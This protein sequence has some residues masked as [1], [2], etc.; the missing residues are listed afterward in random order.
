MIIALVRHAQFHQPDDVPSALLPYG[1]TNTGVLQAEQAGFK[2][3][4]FTEERHL[5]C[6]PHIDCSLMLR[7]WQTAKVIAQTLETQHSVEFEIE[8]H[9]QLAERSLGAVAN[10]TVPEIELAIFGDPRYSTP[11]EGWKTDSD[12]CLP[13]QGAE[14]LTE[15]GLRVAQYL[16]ALSLGK[17][18]LRIVV[19]HGASIRY[20]A[21]HLG[22]L[23]KKAASHLSMHQASP[24]Y[25]EKGQSG[26]WTK[27]EG[28]WKQ[29]EKENGDNSGD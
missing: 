28:D 20:A 5:R 25:L 14:S 17:N 6:V 10:L 21:V 27:I 12:Y 26:G 11:K 9:A 23:D 22:I 29:R 16:Q 18:E 1:L 3:L 24:I 4:A 7:A 8:E 19:G 15:A 2:I 13:F